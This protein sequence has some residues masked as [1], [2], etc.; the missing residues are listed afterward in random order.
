MR[1]PRN[2][3]RERERKRKSERDGKGERRLFERERNEYKQRVSNRC[4]KKRKKTLIEMPYFLF[5]I[6]EINKKKN[7]SKLLFLI[8][9]HMIGTICVPYFILK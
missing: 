4:F 1:S 5:N 2:A 9:Q 6:V 8:I 7:L 3:W